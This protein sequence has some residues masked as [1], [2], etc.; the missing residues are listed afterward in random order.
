MQVLGKAG[1]QRCGQHTQIAHRCQVLGIRQAGGVLEM[2]RGQTQFG[3][4]FVHQGGKGAFATRNGF[5]QRHRGIVTRLHDHT[6][7]QIVHRHLR[8][9]F[10][11]HARA[12]GTP[13]LVRDHDVL[14]QL[15]AACLQGIKDQIG[16]HQLG[17]GSG[18]H[19]FI[20]SFCRDDLST[21]DVHGQPGTRCQTGCRHHRQVTRQGRRLGA[22][23]LRGFGWSRCLRLCLCH[24][25][26]CQGKGHHTTRKDWRC[27]FLNRSHGKNRLL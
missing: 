2:C 24:H 6:L 4:L 15:Q 12:F 1:D 26:Q 5:G 18:L 3:R 14:V 9:D 20:E 23:H 19:L 11:K 13:G 27:K 8:I 7:Q 25:R 21:I 16:C 22:E 17:Q 10:D